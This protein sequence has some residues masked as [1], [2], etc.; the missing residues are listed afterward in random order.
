MESFFIYGILF[1][2]TLFIIAVVSGILQDMSR[3]KIIKSTIKNID[4]TK[5]IKIGIY[6]VLYLD[7]EN[8]KFYLPAYNEK[9]FVVKE[10]KI[11]DIVKCEFI[12]NSQVVF[13]TNMG[14]QVMGTLVGGAI[15]GPVGAVV[16]GASASKTG[17]E[18]NVTY[19]IRI[20]YKDVNDPIDVIKPLNGTK[21]EEALKCYATIEA[22]INSKKAE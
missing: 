7:E 1:V 12:K 19:Q 17:T 4:K 11:K 21:E 18:K 10:R 9:P 15:L 14:S 16:G 3:Q 22:L 2:V 20:Y 6:I 13:T 5:P 8:K